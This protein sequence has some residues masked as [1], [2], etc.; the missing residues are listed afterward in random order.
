MI[1]ALSF[2][3]NAAMIASTDLNM[4]DIMNN[5]IFGNECV[6]KA[7]ERPEAATDGKCGSE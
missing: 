6:I 4:G 5:N 7:D 1:W 2:A 3:S